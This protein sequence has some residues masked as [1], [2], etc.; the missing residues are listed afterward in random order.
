MFIPLSVLDTTV[1]KGSSLGEHFGDSLT[2]TE[3]RSLA[4]CLCSGAEPAI[5]SPD[6]G[7]PPLTHD[8]LRAF[9][10]NFVLPHAA[11]LPPLKQ[12][13]RIMVVLP[14]G[15]E[16]AVA[17]LALGNYHSCAPVNGSCT[18]IELKDDAL[19]LQAKAI[20]TSKDIGKRLNLE[21]LREELNCQIFYINGRISG[22]AGL[23]DVFMPEDTD[24]IISSRPAE[25]HG[26]DDISLILHTS[27]TSGKKKVV[28]YS[29]RTLLVGIW[30]I[31]HSWDLKPVDINRTSHLFFWN[32][33]ICTN[34]SVHIVNMM[35]LFHVGGIMRNLFAP[36]LS[37]GSSIMCIG[38]D[39]NA[40]WS[41]AVSLK[42]TWYMVL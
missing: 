13:D 1:P 15:P 25:A 2:K 39:P 6:T 19:R 42:P 24:V 12:N 28:R 41:L 30:C 9:V 17:L 11:N 40:F 27:G 16:N 31:V 20:I 37:G 26:L 14:P 7:R 3:I 36:I 8:E 32:A 35:P 23:F 18:A 38:F 34:A 21:S 22:P 5:H 4:H 33:R 10:S 29:L